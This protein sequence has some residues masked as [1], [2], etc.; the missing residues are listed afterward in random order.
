[1][2]ITTDLG[3]KTLDEISGLHE[4]SQTTLKDL[5]SSLQEILTAITGLSGDGGSK[6]SSDV[7]DLMKGVVGNEDNKAGGGAA[8]ADSKV[9][10][11]L[12]P[13]VG[14]S[15]LSGLSQ[16]SIMGSLLIN[17]TLLDLQ[18]QVT[19]QLNRIIQQ[20]PSGNKNAPKESKSGT[21]TGGLK[22][23]KIDPSAFKNISSALKEFA[24][25]AVMVSLVPTK[26]VDKAIESFGKFI[27]T[28]TKSAKELGQHMKDFKSFADGIKT[29]VNCLKQYALAVVL[30]AITLPLAPLALANVM[31]MKLMLSMLTAVGKAAKG[32]H[33]A[34]TQLVKSFVMLGVAF[35][36]YGVIMTIL[37]NVGKNFKNA[38]MGLLAMISFLGVVIL[39]GIICVYALAALS[40]V[41]TTFIL[42]GVA[43]ILF[44]VAIAIMQ[45]IEVKQEAIDNVINAV[46]TITTGFSMMAPMIFGSLISI[47]FFLN[48]AVLFTVSMLIFTLG[49]ATL[50][51]TDIILSALN[52]G[53]TGFPV[54]NKIMT[55]IG[56]FT[57][58][59]AFKNLGLG[60]PAMITFIVFSALFTVGMLVFTVGTV[61][62]LITDSILSPITNEDGTNR[63]IIAM[64]TIAKQMAEGTVTWLLGAVALI[65]ALMFMAGFAAFSV[66]S[67]VAAGGLMLTKKSLDRIG[68]IKDINETGD[69][70][71][72]AGIGIMLGFLGM[73]HKPGDKVGLGEMIEA[74][75]NS[76]KLAAVGLA[77]TVAIA[78][79]VAFML[80]AQL[81]GKA[82][83][84]LNESMK[85]VNPQTIELVFNGLS[86]LLSNL[87]VVAE[88]LRGQNAKTITAIGSLVKDVAEAMNM[89]TDIVIKLK[90]GIPEEQINSA[91]YSMNLI[92]ERLF[93][94]PGGNSD[95]YTLTTTLET[96]ANAN[97]KKLNVEAV[98]AIA[99]LMDGIDRMADLVIKLSDENVFSQEKIEVGTKNLSLFLEAMT[100]VST[101]MMSL[102]TYQDT[103]ETQKKGGLLGWMGFTESVKKSP[104]EAIQE[105]EGSGFFS[106]FE[107][108]LGGLKRVSASLGDFDASGVENVVKFLSNSGMGALPFGSS[109]FATSM[110]NFGNG[111]NKINTSMLDNFDRFVK[112]MTSMGN[113]SFRNA[114]DSLVKLGNIANKFQTIA[115]SMSTMA[116][117]MAKMASKKKDMVS[118]FEAIEKSHVKNNDFKVPTNAE[119]AIGG[120]TINPYV[121]KI[122]DVIADW[123]L[124]GIPVRAQF[125]MGTGDIEP[126]NVGNSVGL[127]D[128]RK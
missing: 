58:G 62:L 65:P 13:N 21:E 85:G 109:S 7:G 101:A 102:I 54:I 19:S 64:T 20:M 84:S 32:S 3:S 87:A 68:S 112:T 106:S 15:D 60:I 114:I 72:E 26:V 11:K 28:M 92:C 127:G 22:M 123:N 44:S 2:T 116:D 125:N 23:S 6:M 122:Y 33:P 75:K 42:L 27:N 118:I 103:G 31:I 10:S 104:L 70:L 18:K 67:A 96:I 121:E 40:G 55:M 97:L 46:R 94:R 57:E 108:V 98:G 35:L 12:G 91:T 76:I 89:I 99:P 14:I 83:E 48:F 43:M 71:R 37:I 80:G 79:M 53:E 36:L 9:A 16:G 59:D 66:L 110:E 39:T 30:L 51:L 41:I 17:S 88:S 73:E 63:P 50:L 111:L 8:N 5:Q 24:V 45:R 47:A 38:M 52:P 126:V 86:M 56:Q 1:M 82:F 105:V 115:S 113:D 29:I 117:A 61:F 128:S 25:A 77:A 78:P 124:N 34:I 81:I 49:V 4:D 95:S 69:K 74:T 119:E 107:S 120:T 100:A 90:D 93:G